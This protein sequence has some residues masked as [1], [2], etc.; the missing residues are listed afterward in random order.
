[1]MENLASC[2]HQNIEGQEGNKGP[3]KG[4]FL[5]L[6]GMELDGDSTKK[7]DENYIKKQSDL[8]AKQEISENYE[9]QNKS[10]DIS[11]NSFNKNTADKKD[12]DMKEWD[13]GQDHDGENR[14][15]N[16][17][18]ESLA[19]KTKLVLEKWKSKPEEP[20]SNEAIDI[21]L[22]ND[23][24]RRL[25][26]FTD[27]QAQALTTNKNLQKS[28]FQNNQNRKKSIIQLSLGSK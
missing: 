14:S 24:W 4:N 23:G 28:T 13:W 9:S 11:N 25:S 19:K 21:L 27:N 15:I 16:Q 26:H 5:S 17:L 1:M 18:E 8:T 12:K 6:M 22:S 2:L 7:I 10:L 20:L 3:V